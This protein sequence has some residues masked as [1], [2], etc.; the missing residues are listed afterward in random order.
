MP[1]SGEVPEREHGAA[2]SIS[3][4]ALPC[5]VCRGKGPIEMLI[6]EERVNLCGATGERVLPALPTLLCHR[7]QKRISW[8]C[9]VG[10]HAGD[11]P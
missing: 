9:N 7:C 10:E 4:A 8:P 3:P 2:L 6:Q 11:P 1:G 5:V